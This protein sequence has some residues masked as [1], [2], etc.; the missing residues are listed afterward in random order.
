MDNVQKHNICA[1]ND[2]MPR[3]IEGQNEEGLKTH[4]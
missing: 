3:K 1:K 4:C 2:G